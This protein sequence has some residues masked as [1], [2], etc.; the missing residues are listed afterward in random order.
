ML[1][2]LFS[3]IFLLIPLAGSFLKVLCV[4]VQRSTRVR[5]WKSGPGEWM[6]TAYLPGLSSGIRYRGLD[7]LQA[8]IEQYKTLPPPHAGQRR[9]RRAVVC[10]G[11]AADDRRAL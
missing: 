10:C 8:T 9:H 6:D 5:W 2:G 4:T 3:D 11:V 7:N 1:L